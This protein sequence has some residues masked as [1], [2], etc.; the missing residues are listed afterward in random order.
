MQDDEIERDT[1]AMFVLVVRRAAASA[2]SGIHD[3]APAKGSEF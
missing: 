1:I 2:R 3:P